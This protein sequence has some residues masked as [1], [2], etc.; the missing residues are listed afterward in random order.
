MKAQTDLNSIDIEDI[1]NRKPDQSIV[2]FDS[3]NSIEFIES[4]DRSQSKNESKSINKK[5]NLIEKIESSEKVK[6]LLPS[7]SKSKQF[8]KSIRKYFHLIQCRSHRI[9]PAI[10]DKM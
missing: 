3:K 9:N 7:E 6:L 2:L 4:I 10:G 8:P 5:G 1:R